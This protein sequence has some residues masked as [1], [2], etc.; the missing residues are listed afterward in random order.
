L[1]E[2]GRGGISMKCGVFFF[3]VNI[4]EAIKGREREGKKILIRY[5]VVTLP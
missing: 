1:K 4:N 3:H 5:V 2:K